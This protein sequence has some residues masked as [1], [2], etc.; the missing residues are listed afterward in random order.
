MNVIYLQFLIIQKPIGGV[1]VMLP[2]D[3]NKSR[4]KS[5]VPPET[6]EKTEVKALNEEPYKTGA[7]E[8]ISI[9]DFISIQ[10]DIVLNLVNI[11]A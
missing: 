6:S 8:V 5:P 3:L 10:N 11:I 2:M 7:E 1:A 4:G 9:N